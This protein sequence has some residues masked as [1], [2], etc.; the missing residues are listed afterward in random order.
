MEDN[1]LVLAMLGLACAGI[2]LVIA[3][4]LVITKESSK[5][6]LVRPTPMAT[7]ALGAKLEA[8]AT[9]PERIRD[10]AASDSTRLM[11]FRRIASSWT[12]DRAS[13]I[14][15]PSREAAKVV[16]GVILASLPPIPSVRSA[17]LHFSA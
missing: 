3:G 10:Q 6:D 17:M 8:L 2:M 1:D 9:V 7:S 5:T 15:T 11:I 16:A 4:L 12:L 13:M 14:A